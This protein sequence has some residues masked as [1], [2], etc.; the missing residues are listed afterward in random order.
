MLTSLLVLALTL[1]PPDT[2]PSAV[3]DSVWLCEG[4]AAYAYHHYAD[5]E[6]LERCYYSVARYALTDK[7]RQDRKE[8]GFCRYRHRKEKREGM[9]K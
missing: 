8:C 9:K 2:L 1:T 7:M 4:P 3:V 6:G 5:C